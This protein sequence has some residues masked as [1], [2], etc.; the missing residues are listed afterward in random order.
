ML[1][2]NGQKSILDQIFDEMLKILENDS[3]FSAKLINRL[4][5]TVKK[6]FFKNQKDIENALKG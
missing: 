2:N 3:E 5:D 4:K 1:N 6:N